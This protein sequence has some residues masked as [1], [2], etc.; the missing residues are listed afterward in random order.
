[1]YLH[2]GHIQF[3][4]RIITFGAYQT[5][6][7]PKTEQT[8]QLSGGEIGLTFVIRCPEGQKWFWHAQE[9]DSHPL[10]QVRT[11]Y[12]KTSCS[13]TNDG[14]RV[15]NLRHASPKQS[16]MP[17]SVLVCNFAYSFFRWSCFMEANAPSDA[18]QVKRGK[19]RKHLCTVD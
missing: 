11:D 10:Y 5:L 8:L 6:K 2:T 17:S 19:L 3:I 12:L 16:F 7:R 4:E 15:N 14:E 13:V 1:M 9:N 18:A